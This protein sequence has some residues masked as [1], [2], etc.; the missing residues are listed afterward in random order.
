[1]VKTPEPCR[2]TRS[3]VSPSK[4]KLTKRLLQ[5]NALME[6]CYLTHSK[7]LKNMIK[8]RLN[9]NLVQPQ[10]QNLSRFLVDTLVRPHKMKEVSAITTL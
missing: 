8:N 7:K 4:T 1:M 6:K 3:Q 5:N 2:T 10:N 9:D